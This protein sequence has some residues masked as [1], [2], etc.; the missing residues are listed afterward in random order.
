MANKLYV[1]NFPWSVTENDLRELFAQ[2]GEV[3]S[4]KI[5]M[6]KETGRS[7]GFAFIEFADAEACQEAMDVEN[8]RDFNGR[9]L[10]VREAVDKPRDGQ[11]T[12][13]FTPPRQIISPP[14]SP[15]PDRF[16]G[17]VKRQRER[18]PRRDSGRDFQD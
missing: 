11:P 10:R 7:R 3:K 9:E 5:I 8:G 17:G 13:E 14:P 15:Q 12:R 1:G 4:V 6:D 2:Y 16:D 18:R